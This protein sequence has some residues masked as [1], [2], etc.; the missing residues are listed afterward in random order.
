MSEMGAQDAPRWAA[1]RSPSWGGKL[2]DVSASAQKSPVAPVARVLVADDDEF[3]VDLVTTGLRFVG[4]EVASASTGR[5]AIGKGRE[6]WA[7]VILL[8]VM[9]PD[10]DGFEVCQQLRNDGNHTPIIFLTARGEVEQKVEGL[11]LGADDYI[12]KPFR[13]EEVVA[14]VETVLRRAGKGPAATAAR[15]EVGDLELDEDAHV[16]RR[17]GRRIDLSATEFKVLRYLMA[18]AG[19]VLSRTQILDHV[20]HYDFGGESTVVETYI[21]YL[22]RKVD[23]VEP[24]LIHTIRG[25]GYVLRVDDDR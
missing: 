25:V 11:R 20:W 7:D 14:R 5:E 4:Y 17:G 6:G 22:R 9:M 24:R 3:I 13:L 1:P 19:R 21:S 18:N 8:D 15:Y 23:D 10:R 2:T 16:V 12:T